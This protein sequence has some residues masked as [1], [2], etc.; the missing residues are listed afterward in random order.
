M[1]LARINPNTVIGPQEELHIVHLGTDSVSTCGVP[2]TM[3]PGKRVCVIARAN[4]A[5]TADSL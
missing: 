5:G 3:Y 1:P 4:E 2:S